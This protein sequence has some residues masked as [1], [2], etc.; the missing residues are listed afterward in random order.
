MSMRLKLIAV[1]A[2][3]L[4]GTMSLT[5]W[6]GGRIAGRSVESAIQDRAMETGRALQAKLE[7]RASYDPKGV[8]SIVSTLLRGQRGIRAIEIGIQQ[9]GVKRVMRVE[10][11]PSGPRPEMR[12]E[13][14]IDI[15]QKAT[16][17]L[18]DEPDGR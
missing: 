8:E 15:P 11:T 9:P 6:L 13:Q 2:A 17:A 10:M 3:I 14:S 16:S 1:F 12:D 7:Q 5:A 4:V 18:V